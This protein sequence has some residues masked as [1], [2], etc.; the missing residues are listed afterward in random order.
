MASSVGDSWAVP[1][2]ATPPAGE[3]EG[4]EA[5]ADGGEG[6]EADADDGEGPEAELDEDEGAASGLF[7]IASWSDES[8]AASPLESLEAL[9]ELVP[10]APPPSSAASATS[11]A[12]HGR[13]IM[14]EPR[15]VR[16]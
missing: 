5:D 9:L 3:G 1:P 8:L 6:P 2:G 4:P 16:L 15:R 10:A 7:I 14:G 13:A 11:D 12:V